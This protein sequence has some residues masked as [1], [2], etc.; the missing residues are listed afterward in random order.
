MGRLL[1]LEPFDQPIN[2][3]ED[4][5]PSAIWLE[6]HAVGLAE[7][8]LPE[9][10]PIQGGFGGVVVGERGW[11]SVLYGDGGMAGGPE[12]LWAEY[13]DPKNDLPPGGRDHHTNWLECIKTREKP[14]SHEEIGHRGAS[15]GHLTIVACKLGRSLK[16]D[17]AR[18]V[19][20][21]D[22]QAN[23]LINRAKRAP[24]HT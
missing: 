1:L 21:E 14:S 15:L 24:W 12:A 11:M 7:G 4:A 20:P 5:P 16:W 23:R 19:F 6:G 18:E 13:N 9:G 2:A 8:A 17:P 10:A 3:A 22:E